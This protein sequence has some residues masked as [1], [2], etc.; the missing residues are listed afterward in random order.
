M[1]FMRGISLQRPI[2]A[3]ARRFH[4]V[5]AWLR[6]HPGYAKIRDVRFIL[7]MVVLKGGLSLREAL[8]LRRLG[9]ATDY[10]YLLEVG[11]F[12]G[13]SAAALFDGTF[14]RR[15]LNV[16]V[17]Y[18]IEPHRDFV[19]VY[20][21]HFGPVDRAGFYKTMLLTGA[22][23]GVALIN[24]TSQEAA[25]GWQRPLGLV[26]IDGDHTYEGVADDVRSWEPHLVPGGMLVFDDAQDE[27][28]GPHRVIFE[29]VASGAYVRTS[30]VGKVVALRKQAS[31]LAPDA[32]SGDKSKNIL[33]VTGAL[34]MSGGMLR[35]ERA[36][37]VLAALGHRVVFCALRPYDRPLSWTGV[38][39]V[40]GMEE[41]WA[42]QW[43]VTMLP[44]RA[45]LDRD[46]HGQWLRIFT[47]SRFGLRIQHI[48]ND[49]A[50]HEDAF[51][52]L[53]QEF[54]PHLVI[55]N[56]SAWRP[57]NFTQFTA[58][59]FHVL[60]G[61]VDWQQFATCRRQGDQ[62]GIIIGGQARKNPEPLIACLDLLPAQ[63]RLCLF[64]AAPDALTRACAK[65]IASG[66]IVLVGEL[67]E[68]ELPGYYSGIDVVVS[69]EEH[70]GWS[71]LTAEAMA[72]GVP[73]ICTPAGT[74]AIG[75]DFETALVIT[76][77]DPTLIAAALQ[78]MFKD[79]LLREGL[80]KRARQHVRQYDWSSYTHQLVALM[81]RGR[82]SHYYCEPKLSMY[83][84][85]PSQ[86]RLTGLEM[87]L[88][89]MVGK[90][91]LDIGSAEGVLA[92]A[93]L[94]AGASMVHGLD[95]D[96]VRVAKAQALCGEKAAFFVAD[97]NIVPSILQ[98]GPLM[99]TYDC[100]L[101]LGVHHHLRA[102]IRVAVVRQ[103]ADRCRHIFAL[104]TS[105]EA[106]QKDALHT[107]LSEGG[108]TLIQDAVQGA[109][110]DLGL[111]WTYSR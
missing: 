4:H 33:I 93:C 100:I 35:F 68:A 72:A 21:G 23:Q 7:L 28:I 41:A 83:G 76:Q 54:L 10:G 6:S 57:G 95:V 104:R 11:S 103:L 2:A 50:H 20:G 24:L 99:P 87:T 94:D 15:A 97:L 111:L 89:A 109:T 56:N 110:S 85:W 78:C 17:V 86:D 63:Y 36:G 98:E 101:Y 70:A 73:V 47:D 67:A 69:T 102:D 66:R 71:N 106:Y 49:K 81:E 48:L 32:T 14:S 37:K 65:Y 84:K 9:R 39:P 55:F 91:V 8:Y 3:L 31:L 107:V 18:C 16:P 44:G 30:A 42:Q 40:I 1:A 90:S 77:P 22:Y 75:I 82:S 96:R 80:I 64:G 34:F 59:E 105:E 12:R 62:S 74:A 60:I 88:A 46:D 52:Q 45:D 51:R 79:T 26:F 108:F 38:L 19:G 43:D 13:K 29:L 58:N 25:R 61:G 92:K 5:I 27:R 53:N